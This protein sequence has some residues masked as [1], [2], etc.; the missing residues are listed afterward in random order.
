MINGIFTLV[1]YDENVQS[2][3]EVHL[4]NNSVIFRDILEKS[5]LNFIENN[6]FI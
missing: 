2:E 4:S 1:G 5:E 6:S 3:L